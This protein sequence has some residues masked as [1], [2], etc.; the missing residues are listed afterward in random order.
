MVTGRGVLRIRGERGSFYK[1]RGI[2]W[3]G[4]LL[5]GEVG[6][7]GS[8]SWVNGFVLFLLG[9]GVGALRIWRPQT[10][11]R[12][13]SIHLIRTKKGRGISPMRFYED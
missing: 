7:G 13:V 4:K 12:G 6:W 10:D 3:E 8:L 2:S 5:N 1:Y 9:C 11:V